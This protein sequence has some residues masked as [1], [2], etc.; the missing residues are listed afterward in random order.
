MKNKEGCDL[1]MCPKHQDCG[2]LYPECIIVQV[3]LD[4]KSLLKENKILRLQNKSLLSVIETINNTLS[5]LKET[6]K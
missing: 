3:D 6:Q 4:R 1:M 2:M 5:K